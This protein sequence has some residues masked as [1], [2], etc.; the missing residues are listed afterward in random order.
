MP[1]VRLSLGWIPNPKRPT[2]IFYNAV[3]PK[4]NESFLACVSPLKERV[5][6]SESHR[7]IQQFRKEVTY[8]LMG[9]NFACA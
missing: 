9:D 6:Q 8:I 7:Q 5:K 2:G 3:L 1:W 4:F